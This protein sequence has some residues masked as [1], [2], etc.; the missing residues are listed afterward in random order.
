MGTPSAQSTGYS[1]GRTRTKPRNGSAPS[2]SWNPPYSSHVTERDI[3]EDVSPA[4]VEI[5][6]RFQEV[7]GGVMCEHRYMQHFNEEFWNV[8]IFNYINRLNNVIIKAPELEQ[9]L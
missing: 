5:A 7:R 8:V 2:G 3:P 1:E 9:K 6:A 4:A